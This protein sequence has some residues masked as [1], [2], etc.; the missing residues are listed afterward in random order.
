MTLLSVSSTLCKSC[1]ILQKQQQE[2]TKSAKYTAER[3]ISA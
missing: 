1:F 3:T 2:M